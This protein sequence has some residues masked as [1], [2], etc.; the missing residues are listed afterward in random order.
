L[1]DSKDGEE[2]ERICEMKE[3]REV[4]GEKEG[5]NLR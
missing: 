5:G 1:E 3:R 2:R 4:T